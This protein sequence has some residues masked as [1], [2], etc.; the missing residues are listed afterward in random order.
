MRPVTITICGWG[1]YRDIQTI[2]FDKV[3]SRGLFLICGPTGAGK[4]TIFDAITYALYGDVSGAVREKS[5]VRSDFAD[6]DTRTYVSLTMTHDGKS[7]EIYRSPEYLRP[8]KRGGGSQKLTKE[9]ERAVLSLEQ[10]VIVEGMTDVTRKVT[11]ILRLN[12]LQFKQLSMIAQGEFTKLLTASPADKTKIFRDLFGTHQ[13]EML[14]TVLREHTNSFYREVMEYRHKMEE[15]TNLYHPIEESQEYSELTK[16]DRMD[17]DAF[18]DYL[19]RKKKEEK[20]R[21][22]EIQ[23]NLENLDKELTKLK[24]VKRNIIEFSKKEESC[25]RQRL[26]Y[27]SLV[28]KDSIYQKKKIQIE[29]ARKAAVLRDKYEN[30]EEIRKRYLKQQN[31]VTELEKRISSICDEL[32]K[33]QFLNKNAE[34]Y[35]SY[36]QIQEVY[37]GLK[38]SV[39]SSER[40][41]TDKTDE[42]CKLQEKYLR[43]ENITKEARK[44]YETAQEQLR[45]NMAGILAGE[46][47]EKAPCPVC[48]ALEHPS[49][50]VLSKNSITDKQVQIYKEEYETENQRL[51]QMFGTTRAEKAEVDQVNQT[52]QEYQVQL[53]ELKEKKEKLPS[54]VIIETAIM[55]K[56]EYDKKKKHL[57]ELEILKQE[58]DG[59]LKQEN[60]EEIILKSDKEVAETSFSHLMKDTGFVSEDDLKE[61]LLSE[62]EMEKL[63]S[64]TEQYK[65]QLEATKTLLQHLQNE[66]IEQKNK[67]NINPNEND[68]LIEECEKR[69][70]ELG[71]EKNESYHFLE[72][73]KKLMESI[74]EKLAKSREKERL[75]GLWKDMD[76]VAC[77]NNPGRMVF[78]QYVLS[79]Y[80][81]Q[82]LEAANKRLKIMSDERY[83]LLR[84]EEVS[85]KRTKDNLE[86]LVMDY[87]TG[88]TRSVKS[89]S[90][91]ETFKASLSLAL[92]LSDIVQARSG[93]IKVDALFIDEGFGSLD[94]QSLEQAC[95]VLTKLVENDRMIG[96]ISHVPELAEKI[97]HQVRIHKT[98]SGSQI[99]TVLS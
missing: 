19:K 75:Y 68:R 79:V 14:G 4:T 78:E 5:S 91:G 22:S 84:A 44:V 36:Y 2:D 40:A 41:V 29:K 26:A 23:I 34:E 3:A 67:I 37:A 99:E 73:V 21:F 70:S 94:S 51:L 98:N 27:Q 43:Q 92:G 71:K 18:L 52:L 60:Q 13:M 7:Y 76:D 15:D 96:I 81:D 82:I 11:E 46:L 53:K 55:T 28:E 8:S 72:E 80:F 93:G 16:S 6:M 20:N 35:D 69:K 30:L 24:E 12:Y 1:P 83:E 77:G 48:G 74:E 10:E 95:L 62:E 56:A 97:D 45:H 64:D 54:E 59:S 38:N 66:L 85:D 50:A 9:K 42:L 17:Y 57:N 33:L 31:R 86:I 58:L 32:G 47:K 89:L 90:G 88:R 49:P 63:S 39:N 65:K 61:V 25:E 87:Y